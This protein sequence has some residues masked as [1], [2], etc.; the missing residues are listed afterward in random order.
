MVDDSAWMISAGG[1]VPNGTYRSLDAGQNWAKV[2]DGLVQDFD[3]ATTL[4]GFAQAGGPAYVTYDGGAH[5]R[6]QSAGGAIWPGVMDVWAFD[7]TRAA[8]AEVGFGDPNGA[9][10]LFTYVEPLQASLEARAHVPL[11][12]ASVARGATNVPLAS[13]RVESFGPTPITNGTLTLRA[14]GSL[15][16][17]LQVTAVRVWLDR[18]GDGAIDADDIQLASGAFGADE[19]TVALTVA[20]AGALEQ[21]SPV[22]LLVTADL[23]PASAYSGTLRVMLAAANFTGRESGGTTVTAVAPTGFVMASRTLTVGP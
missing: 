19:G 20:A 6:Y 14:S 22:H 1:S 12:D 3:F 4:K 8:W 5:W 17:A 16:D 15:D 7:R 13:Y 23:S 10:Q 18:D 2:S 9:G 21:L 11:A